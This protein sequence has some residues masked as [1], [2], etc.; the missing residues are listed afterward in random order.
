MMLT[1]DG[2]RGGKTWQA[3]QAI[4]SFPLTYASYDDIR[5]YYQHLMSYA[6][7]ATAR[8]MLTLTCIRL[9]QAERR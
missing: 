4:H 1:A 7:Q 9:G 6:V 3:I 2:S 8:D 5:T